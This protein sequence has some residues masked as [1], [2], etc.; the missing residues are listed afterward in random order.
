MSKKMTIDALRVKYVEMLREM[1]AGA[2]EEV[3]RVGSNEIAIPVVDDEGEDQYV[4]FKV[5][6]PSGS[7]DGE[8]YDAYG[9]A[10]AY[11]MHQA[12]KKERAE[13]TARDKAAKIARDAA[14]R[15]AKAEAKANHAAN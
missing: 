3:L 8:A 13:K 10:E 4:V 7:R 15:K 9:L 12:E 2:E 6:V 11:A 1:L 14:A 5:Q